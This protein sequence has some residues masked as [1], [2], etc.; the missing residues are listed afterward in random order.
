MNDLWDVEGGWD[1]SWFEG[2][3]EDDSWVLNGWWGK[4]GDEH[5]KQNM[6]GNWG[7]KKVS[8][9]GTLQFYVNL[10]ETGNPGKDTL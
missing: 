10:G 6:G 7:Y 5:K 2:G 9:F 8:L 3:R 4:W 1:D